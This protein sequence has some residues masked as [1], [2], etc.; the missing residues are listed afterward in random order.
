MK[1]VTLKSLRVENFGNVYGRVRDVIFGNRTTIKGRN[2][3][4]KS[5]LGD[6]YSWTMTNKLMNGNA[7]DG[8][9][10][11]DENGVDFDGTDIT[12]T[13]VLDIDGEE[14]RIRKTQTQMYAKKTGEFKG[15]NNDYMINEIPKKEKDFKE[16]LETVASDEV[17]Q[18]C[19]SSAAFLKLDTKKRRQR[20]FEM[21]PEFSDDDVV[22]TNDEFL[23]IKNMFKD[24]T[25]EELIAR[26][27]FQL[28]G[29]GRQDKGLNGQLDDMKPR[30]DEASKGI[31][32][33]AEYEL[34]IN[35]LKEQIAE[36]DKQEQALNDSIA[37]YDKASRGILDLKLEQSEIDR[38][39]NEGLVQRKRVLND[40]IVDLQ[41][42]KREAENTLRLAEMDL[43]HA[44]MAI[45]RHEADLKTAQEDWKSY[46]N[47][48]FDNENLEKIKAEEPDENLL[49]CPTCGQGLPVEQA[50]QI[51]AEF[52]QKKATRI[53]EQEEARDAFYKSKEL[54]LVSI[55]EA[56][57]KA[58]A[59]LK[60][61]QN[62]KEEAE[63]KISETKGKIADLIIKITAKQQELS[64][65]PDS[66]DLSENAE[67]QTISAEITKQEEALKQM[68][69]GEE[70]RREISGKR[71][72]AVS[73]IARYQQLIKQSQDAQDR[74]AELQQEQ[75]NLSQRIADTQRELDLL[76]SFQKAK[77]DML[78]EKINSLFMFTKWQ[79]FKPQ[80]NG[81]FAEV[82]EPTFKGTAYGR[83][84]N[85]GAK[86]LI[87]LDICY[88]FQ[89]M[90]DI[91]VP[92]WLDNAERMTENT[93]KMLD[94]IDT[95]VIFLKAAEGDL[96][97]EAHKKYISDMKQY[98]KDVEKFKVD[99]KQF[100]TEHPEYPKYEDNPKFYEHLGAGTAE[101]WDKEREKEKSGFM[102]AP[103]EPYDS[104]AHPE[105]VKHWESIVAGKIP[106]GLRLED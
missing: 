42:K 8:I 57:N 28:N 75:K 41:I 97:V 63:K 31:C 76:K 85:D 55:T 83:R 15:N 72:E 84:L 86:A 16:F 94:G 96:S 62:A 30:I 53:K 29:R 24:G 88:T 104:A 37:A 79:L 50:G 48:E 91:R 92:I 59:D 95:Q 21:V 102:F 106:F 103:R 82:C 68:N 19:T 45:Q 36:L 17:F 13:A 78:T 100:E 49:I 33:V 56:G 5:T 89:K 71:N 27:N 105:V 52:E 22:A 12:V 23:P 2:E 40:E 46:A 93:L 9:R 26:A 51:K 70:Q 66:V 18:L 69:N 64:K 60:E 65:L 44:D 61:A 74:V 34:A 80:V 77:C 73:E 20:L 99:V 3:S 101:E 14:K 11:H 58:A 67:Y 25:V 81:D 6:A 4:G 90:N 54:K 38:K 35:G 47:K 1:R 10:P 43:K 87:D 98:Q 7:A 32:D 39:A